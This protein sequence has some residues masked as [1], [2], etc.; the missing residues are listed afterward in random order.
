MNQSFLFDLYSLSFYIY[1]SGPQLGQNIVCINNN[2][3]NNI[4][5]M[6]KYRKY[7]NHP[8]QYL[9]FRNSHIS[10]ASK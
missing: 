4:I 6:K 2:N 5:I 1:V 7:K 3:D 8:L 9:I 10:V